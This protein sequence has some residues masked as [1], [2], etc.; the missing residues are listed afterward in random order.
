MAELI[1]FF[2]KVLLFYDNSSLTQH[3]N[4]G[5]PDKS[6]LGKQVAL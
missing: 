6:I 1:I 4:N 5:G 3:C 2:K